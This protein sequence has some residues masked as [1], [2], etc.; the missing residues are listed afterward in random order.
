[1]SE[2]PPNDQNVDKI[3]QFQRALK[4]CREV[5]AVLV[6]CDG[7]EDVT[8][9]WETRR[10]AELCRDDHNNMTGNRFGYYGKARVMP[11]RLKTEKMALD[12]FAN[13][14]PNG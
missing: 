9:V 3:K 7:E 4:D 11:M 13:G 5:F 8:S 10:A 6:R 14:A 12:L 2:Q 1:M